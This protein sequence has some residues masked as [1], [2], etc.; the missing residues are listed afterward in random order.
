MNGSC[1]VG[2]NDQD[3][4]THSTNSCADV[5]VVGRWVRISDMMVVWVKL[6]EKH[7]RAWKAGQ[8]GPAR[9]AEFKAREMRRLIERM[10]LTTIRDFQEAYPD[11]FPGVT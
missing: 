5:A 8:L 10:I 7:D 6:C 9:G 3:Y 11:M 2:W 1:Q 4:Q